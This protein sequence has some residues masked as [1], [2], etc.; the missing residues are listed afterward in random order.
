[1]GCPSGRP[2]NTSKA[3]DDCTYH[4]ERCNKCCQPLN[5]K[6]ELFSNAYVHQVSVGCYLNSDGTVARLVK[7]SN[8]LP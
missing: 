3:F 6:T 5:S 2:D 8:V 4:Y 1:M 7:E